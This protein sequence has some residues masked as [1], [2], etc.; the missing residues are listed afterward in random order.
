MIG[1]PQ[2]Y[3]YFEQMQ[4][5]ICRFVASH[6]QI[7]EDA[8]RR[9]MMRTDEMATDMGTIL[10]GEEAVRAGIIDRVGGLADAIAALREMAKDAKGT[11]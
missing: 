8:L 7:T 4:A 2:T 10:G 5:R 6:S 9:L 1:A 11:A 3:A